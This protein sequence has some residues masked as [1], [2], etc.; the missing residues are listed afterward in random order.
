MELIVFDLDGTLLNSSSIISNYTRDTL[1]LLSEKNITYTVATGRT[2]HSASS[3]IS[4]NHF[5]F[6][7]IYTN[8]VIVWDPS[9]KSVDINNCLAL[10]EIQHVLRAAKSQN[11]TPFIFI[12][13]DDGSHYFYHLEDLSTIEQQLLKDFLSRDKLNQDKL[14][15]INENSNI[16]N[17][18]LIASAEKIDAIEKDISNEQHLIT[19]SGQAIEGMGYKWMDV[20]HHAASKG[21]AIETLKKQYNITKVICFGDSDNDLSMFDIADESYAPENANDTIKSAATSIIGH[22]NDDGVA[23]FLR[24]RFKL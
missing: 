6:P 10:S 24:D 22:H 21:G 16:T 5:T 11:V 7:H 13:S 18:S 17:I 15:N 8:G 20:H 19:Y 1:R 4:S 3:I 2:L 23:N 12:T 9:K 14:S